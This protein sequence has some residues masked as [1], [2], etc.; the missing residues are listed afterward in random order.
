MKPAFVKMLQEKEQPENIVKLVEYLRKCLKKSR[1]D[2]AKFYKKWDRN[3][4]VYKGER[5]EDEEDEEATELG[6]PVKTAV[7][8]SY[9]Q[10][11][12]FCAF[13][14]MLLMQNKKFYQMEPTGD[15]DYELNEVVELLLERDLRWNKWPSKLYQFLL[16][17]SRFGFAVT[18]EWWDI[19][20]IFVE[21]PVEE[22][23]SELA[24]LVGVEAPST[25]DEE[26]TLFEGN[27]IENV[28]PYCFFP[29]TRVPL[30]KWSEG[31]FAACEYECNISQLRTEARAGDLVGVEHIDAMDRELWKERESSRL[32]GLKKEM[33]G[34]SGKNSDDDFMVVRTLIQIKLIPSEYGLGPEKEYRWFI[35]KLANDSRIVSIEPAGYLHGQFIFNV[36]QLSPDMQTLINES[37]S[38]VI[39]GMQDIVTWLF[40]SR[41][42]SVRNSLE[43]H[44]V[45]DPLMI[46]VSDLEARSPII[47]TTKSAPKTGVDKFIK[48]LEVRDTTASHF[49]DA[50]VIMRTMMVVTGVND[51]AMG[52]VAAGRRSATENRAAN[53][54]AASRMKMQIML[55]FVDALQPQG[56]KLL[57]NQ[58]QGMSMETFVK[59]VGESKAYLFD[60]FAPADIRSL[61]GNEDFFV[62][63]TTQQSEKGFLAQSLQELIV[64]M[65]GNPQ[66]LMA[67]GFDLQAAIKELQFLRGLN[68]ATRFFRTNPASAAGTPAQDPAS[69]VG[70][71]PNALPGL[72]DS[73]A[74]AALGMGASVA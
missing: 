41:V 10:V 7:P 72:G 68:N 24:G 39:H 20:T 60:K 15:E 9:A 11:Q 31:Q 27:K 4:Q 59:I 21:L 47:K 32:P 42:L 53:A 67:T 25:R 69:T 16:D 48:Q 58:R 23:I 3:L 44:V 63:D 36:A 43:N 19:E 13:A 6:E 61:V 12:T 8:M 56:R 46:D 30:T 62:F 71:D 64:A 73:G 33:S 26:V 37:L 5:Y 40:N 54:G 18:K 45:V 17:L 1:G 57:S 22:E 65:I 70:G 52:Q 50:D 28:D 34:R 38:D 51:N 2:M 14:F 35:I 29:D 49:A 74:G 66:V 55:A